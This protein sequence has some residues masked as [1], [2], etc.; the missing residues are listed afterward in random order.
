MTFE[1]DR[2]GQHRQD[3]A[4]ALRQ[5][6]Q[7]SGLT[8]DR[9]AARVGMS[10]AKISK[11]ENGRVLPSAVDVERILHAWDVDPET[12]AAVLDLTRV[13]NTEYNGL[14]E[15]LRLGAHEI[16]RELAAMEASATRMRY[17]LPC[18]ITGLLQTPEYMNT[19]MSHP[20]VSRGI[21]R[22]KAVA[23]KLER[24]SVL[25]DNTKSFTFI[26]TEAALRWSICEPAAMAMQMDRIA[27]VSHLPNVTIGVIPQ[28]SVIPVCPLNGFVIYDRRMV[29]VEIKTGRIVLRDPKD[30]A[31]NEELFGVFEGHAKCDADA[32]ELLEGLAFE[33]R[34]RAAQRR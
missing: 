10:Q 9:L 1:P 16:Q 27:S 6:R 5:L 23:R 2:A 8:G 11:I 4:S 30:I 7:T 31:H 25:Y 34:E 19:V 12:S 15:R 32:R 26:L 29:T 14:R 28:D 20:L 18:A 3:L 13:A 17:F 21:P 22:D 24:Q 33:Y